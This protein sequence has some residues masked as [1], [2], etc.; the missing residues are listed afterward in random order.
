MAD[1]QRY[2]LGIAYQAGPD[3]KIKKGLDGRRE[4]ISEVELEKAAFHFLRNGPVA[5]LFHADG[6]QGAAEIVESYIYRGPDW[7]V[8]GPDGAM[9]TVKK[10]DWL[11]GAI[12]SPQAWDLYKRGEIT[13]WSPQ[14]KARRANPRSSG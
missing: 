8:S 9:T 13:G 5:G 10:G 4:F 11:V 12:L 6:T 3:P 1:E 2:V 14:G 7:H